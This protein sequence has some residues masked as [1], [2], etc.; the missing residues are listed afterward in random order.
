[1]HFVEGLL[2]WKTF[3]LFEEGTFKLPVDNKHKVK[4]I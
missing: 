2:N 4:M 1:M 3:E